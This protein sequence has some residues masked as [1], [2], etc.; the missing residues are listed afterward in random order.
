[1]EVGGGGEEGVGFLGAARPRAV[2]RAPHADL[3]RAVCH[4][5][6][7]TPVRWQ[8]TR[9]PAFCTMPAADPLRT[10]RAVAPPTRPRRGGSW[11][12]T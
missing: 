2:R 3:H 7:G 5:P 11:G 6:A 8:P 12:R 9:R 10:P 1:M 4:K